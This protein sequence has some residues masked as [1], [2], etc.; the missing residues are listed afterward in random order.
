M[1]NNTATTM[2]N[3]ILLKRE[4]IQWHLRNV[5]HLEIETTSEN[6][7]N[8][9]N[10]RIR[11]KKKALYDKLKNSGRSSAFVRI[12]RDGRRG[13]LKELKVVKDEAPMT[14]EEEITVTRTNARW[15]LGNVEHLEI[16]TNAQWPFRGVEHLGTEAEPRNE[17]IE[18]KK[19]EL[20]RKLKGNRLSYA[21]I[22]MSK[23]GRRGLVTELKIFFPE[24]ERLNWINARRK[25]EG[26]K[27]L[28]L[29]TNRGD[30]VRIKKSELIR[31]ME[32]EPT[33]SAIVE[34][35]QG[36][37]KAFVKKMWPPDIG[38]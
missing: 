5:E 34:F 30:S 12:S 26:V 10:E 23:D 14:T 9:G 33:A 24:E 15:S 2:A 8:Q 31:Q 36:R 29:E 21:S 37:K 1:K 13:L 19:K 25:M 22:Q 28:R 38:K 17:R 6:E 27:K 16:E 4:T 18:I 20:Y 3:E 32:E 7:T 35:S 11:I